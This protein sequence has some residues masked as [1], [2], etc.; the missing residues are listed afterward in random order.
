MTDG[1]GITNFCRIVCEQIERRNV[2]KVLIVSP[3]ITPRSS[4]DYSLERII[5]SMA[6]S[7]EFREQVL[8]DVATRPPVLNDFM[9]AG[10]SHAEA[11]MLLLKHPI[12]NISIV[13]NLHT[14]FYHVQFKNEFMGGSFSSFGSA[15]WTW[16]AESNINHE[17]MLEV[18]GN[19]ESLTNM[20]LRTLREIRPLVKLNLNPS[21]LNKF[22][23]DNAEELCKYLWK[24]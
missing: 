9:G 16:Q 5:Q 6:K 14:K 4:S 24:Y 2:E 22:K 13:P 10:K 20:F 8:L 7:R 3:W 15:N 12:T 18:R 1:R 23:I 19:N 21:Q 17:T 11:I